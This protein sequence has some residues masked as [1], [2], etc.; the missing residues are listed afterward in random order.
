MTKDEAVKLLDDFYDEMKEA[1]QLAYISCNKRNE[2][3]DCLF[4]KYSDILTKWKE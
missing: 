1:E 4:D 2:Q 3:M